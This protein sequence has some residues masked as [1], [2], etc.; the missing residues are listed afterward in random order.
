MSLKAE[1][2]NWAAA[3]KAYDEEDFEQSLEL[4]SVRPHFFLLHIS[5]T[6]LLLRPSPTRRKSSQTW[7]LFTLPL[8]SMKLLS[9]NSLLPPVLTTTLLSRQCHPTPPSMVSLS[10]ANSRYFQCGVS[11]FLLGRYDLASKDFE[12]ALLY[13]RGNQSMWVPPYRCSDFAHSCNITSNYTQ[14][15]LA[16]TLYSAEVLFN[17]GELLFNS[18]TLFF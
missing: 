11:N 18:F 17:K 2:E 5:L 14:L 12:G 13:L 4:F 8:A 3:L 7:V 15:G 10:S 1:L 9:S 16:F 6:L